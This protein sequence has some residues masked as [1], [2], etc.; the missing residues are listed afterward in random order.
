MENI[1]QEQIENKL[2]ENIFNIMGEDYHNCDIKTARD[3][4]YNHC[5][6]VVIEKKVIY[7]ILLRNRNKNKN[8]KK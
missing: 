6:S 1:N 7:K 2:I 5:N 4:I 8:N 3:K